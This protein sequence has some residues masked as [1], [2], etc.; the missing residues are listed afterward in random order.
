[1]RRSTC[2]QRK[3]TRTCS[4]AAQID[5]TAG[6]SSRLYKHHPKYGVHGGVSASG[7]VHP[8]DAALRGTL[9]AVAPPGRA[10]SS[11]LFHSR[12]ARS[13]RGEEAP[14][15]GSGSSPASCVVEAETKDHLNWELLNEAA[16]TWKGV[17]AARANQA[18]DRMLQTCRS[19]STSAVW[20]RIGTRLA[21][22]APCGS[23]K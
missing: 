11:G 4:L 10:G 14:R 13:L 12:R 23:G 9:A 16:D 2:L 22:T 5:E 15:P 19:P 6:K 3:R 21:L 18:C 8:A 1:M 7:R 20:I 17:G